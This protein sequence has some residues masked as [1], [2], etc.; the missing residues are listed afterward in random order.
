M[1]AC[2]TGIMMTL[3]GLN[4]QSGFRIVNF[5]SVL[6]ANTLFIAIWQHLHICLVPSLQG[7]KGQLLIRLSKVV[8]NHQKIYRPPLQEVHR[9]AQRH[10]QQ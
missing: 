7:K 4:M 2:N 5:Y 8:M 9:E 3:R 1:V 6:K 10:H